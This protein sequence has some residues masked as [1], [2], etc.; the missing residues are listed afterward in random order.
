MT[1]EYFQLLIET[2]S[3]DNLRKEFEKRNLLATVS[4]V[5]S[6]FWSQFFSIYDNKDL[7][8]NKKA[9][10]LDNLLKEYPR[11]NHKVE[12]QITKEVILYFRSM[13]LNFFNRFWKTKRLI[14]QLKELE[15]S[16]R[17]QK[18]LFRARYCLF[19]SFK[20]NKKGKKEKLACWALESILYDVAKNNGQYDPTWI[21]PIFE[22]WPHLVRKEN[23]LP[24]LTKVGF[25]SEKAMFRPLLIQNFNRFQF[26][27][28]AEPVDFFK[29]IILY[30]LPPDVMDESMHGFSHRR[31]NVWGEEVFLSSIIKNPIFDRFPLA[32]YLTKHISYFN[33]LFWDQSHILR[34]LF[35]FIRNWD[36]WSAPIALSFLPS[37]Q[38][39][40]SVD[41]LVALKILLGGLKFELE[42]K[43]EIMDHIKKINFLELTF[44]DFWDATVDLKTLS[45]LLEESFNI[46]EPF[47][48][49]ISGTEVTFE[50]VVKWMQII[51]KRDYKQLISEP[52]VMNWLETRLNKTDERS[53][54]PM[55]RLTIAVLSDFKFGYQPQDLK[56]AM[57][58][59][60]ED[61]LPEHITFDERQRSIST[62]KD[63]LSLDSEGFDQEVVESITNTLNIEQILTDIHSNGQYDYNYF[64][65]RFGHYF[66]SNKN[67]EHIWTL[68]KFGVAALLPRCFTNYQ[69]ASIGIF[70]DSLNRILE[71]RQELNLIETNTVKQCLL[72]IDTSV[73]NYYTQQ[74]KK[75]ASEIPYKDLTIEEISLS[76]VERICSLITDRHFIESFLKAIELFI[77]DSDNLLCYYKLK[78][79]IYFPKI[80]WL[81]VVDL[82][83]KVLNQQ[84]QLDPNYL[85][86][87]LKV[88]ITVIRVLGHLNKRSHADA[89]TKAVAILQTAVNDN[90]LSM[91]EVPKIIEN[92]PWAYTEL[93]E[94]VLSGPSLSGDQRNIFLGVT[95]MGEEEP[96]LPDSRFEPERFEIGIA[97]Y[98]WGV[99]RTQ[100]LVKG[101]MDTREESQVLETTQEVK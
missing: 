69:T 52:Q 63:L 91:E 39:L 99:E 18:I 4:E 76:L 24:F 40:R 88:K 66:E 34:E 15:M 86:S 21:N 27:H 7:K 6:S 79:S 100:S 48:K 28:L 75:I 16:Y 45:D 23:I 98:C 58:L 37:I 60:I 81:G 84:Y 67:L 89:M 3:L 31:R 47:V 70:I 92:S 25:S 49:Y 26:W 83:L 72:W 80:R 1:D 53:I 93:G 43:K 33:D 41:Q 19:L 35:L 62:F 36:Q 50:D 22:D 8:H 44:L 30:D 13:G 95:R 32:K 87:Y 54:K 74:F 97:Y 12:G 20:I 9:K 64:F 78:E 56:N 71:E 65:I 10:E 11:L 94:R 2:T 77:S 96:T 42:P 85:M 68:T 59:I 46:C 82:I 14:K 101:F 51:E 38:N 55:E 57:F 17:N 90:A 61:F 73:K 29:V 5:Q